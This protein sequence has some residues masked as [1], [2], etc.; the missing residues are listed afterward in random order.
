MD[1]GPPGSSVHG[2]SHVRILEWVAILFSRG[3]SRPKD[4]TQVSCVGRWIL[5][6]WVT[7]E[8]PKGKGYTPYFPVVNSTFQRSEVSLTRF[9]SLLLSLLFYKPAVLPNRT[10]WSLVNN[11]P[12]QYK[13]HPGERR[14]PG[15]DYVVETLYLQMNTSTKSYFMLTTLNVSDFTN[16]AHHS[17]WGNAALPIIRL[18]EGSRSPW[19]VP[20]P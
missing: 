19:T 9:I 1:C 5:Y 8:A 16:W 20:S 3:S 14:W 7:R 4:G 11:S 18:R 13:W 15:C 2:I 17:H 12:P 10:F 6:H